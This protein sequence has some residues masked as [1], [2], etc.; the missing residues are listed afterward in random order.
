MASPLVAVI[1]DEGLRRQQLVGI[2]AGHALGCQ[3]HERFFAQ[4]LP[5]ARFGQ[6]EGSL[7]HD[8]GVEIAV[9]HRAVELRRIAGLDEH[10]DLGEACHH[11]H[12]DVGQDPGERIGARAEAQLSRGRLVVGQRAQV[13]DVAQQL[14][15]ALE[16]ARASLGH[17]HGAP[18]A[19]DQG[20]ADLALERADLLRHRGRRDVEQT[21]GRGHRAAIDYRHEGRQELGVHGLE[22]E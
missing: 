16:D 9:L 1:T 21:R 7:Q 20:G 14:S 2:G 11:A 8:G 15:R 22:R 4:E 6:G 19:R 12:E 10:V 18:D 13:G 3:H 5:R 17:A